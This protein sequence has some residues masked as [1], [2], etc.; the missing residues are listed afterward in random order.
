[1]VYNYYM[2][3]KGAEMKE[4]KFVCVDYM[5]TVHSEEAKDMYKE[6]RKYYPCNILKFD[7]NNSG[8]IY[9]GVFD[10]KMVEAF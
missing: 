6:I 10:Y 3:K 2:I 1:M 5:F 7:K 8:W 9:I 4:R